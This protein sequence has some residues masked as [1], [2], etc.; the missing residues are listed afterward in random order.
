MKILFIGHRHHQKTLSSRFFLDVL[1]RLGEIFLLHIDPAVV[2]DAASLQDLDLSSID[3]VVLWQIDFLAAFFLSR[4]FP[5]VVV[6]ML[7]ASMG[8]PPCHW[9]SMK[10][11]LL[12]SFSRRI[13]LLAKSHGL[14]SV[15]LR[16]FP[17]VSGRSGQDTLIGS[18]PLSLFFWER[19]PRYVLNA[20]MVVSSFSGLVDHIHVHQASDVPSVRSLPHSELSCLSSRAEVSCSQWLA[21]KEAL[22][23]LILAS[24]IYIAPRLSEGIG[25]SF[26]EAMS[27]GRLVVAHDEGTHSDYIVSGRNGYLV[28]FSSGPDLSSLDF[29][30]A[31]LDA[32]AV[33]LR[34]D[35]HRYSRAWKDLYLDAAKSAV[36]GYVESFE[37]PFLSCCIP[38]PAIYCFAAHVD[39][40]LY[41]SMLE[42]WRRDDFWSRSR[43]TAVGWGIQF[44]ESYGEGSLSLI[45]DMACRP[46]IAEN[47]SESR[48]LLAFARRFRDL[49]D[50]F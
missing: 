50:C 15:Y 48:S 23:R 20:A 29:S 32:M 9:R 7:D 26:L 5:V 2:D 14:E 1:E 21:D 39:V 41:S 22:K 16:Y 37:S 27:L 28:D 44:L 45:E 34:D 3:V 8:L 49:R 25:H 4:G 42:L 43:S 12:L 24:Q 33:S 19:N 36:R 31:T 18:R 6:P 13:H 47:P 17:E 10:G 38:F 35:S 40:G 30:I 46:V 11:A